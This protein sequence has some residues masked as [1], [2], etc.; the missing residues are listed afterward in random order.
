MMRRIKLFVY[1]ASRA[2]GL[3]WLARR[4]RLQRGLRILCYHGI[5]V[6]DGYEWKPMLFMRAETFE[7]RLATIRKLGL[8]VLDLEEAVKRMYEGSLPPNTVVITIDDGF[9]STFDAAV[10]ALL[11]FRMPATIYVTTYY[12]LKDQPIFELVLRYIHWKIGQS[13]DVDLAALG[14]KEGSE[15]VRFDQRV[16][17]RII[18]FGKA[19]PAEADRERV[20]RELAAQL[21]FDYE[22]IVHSGLLTL[23]SP[24]QIVEA[25]R[26]GIDIQLHTRR[27]RFP[28]IE[29]LAKAEIK[30]NRRDMEPIIGTELAHFCY[31]SGKW[32]AAQWPWLEELGVK[33]ATTCE[34]GLNYR[35]TPRYALFR[36]LDSDALSLVEFEAE[37]SG[38]SEIIRHLRTW[39]RPSRVAPGNCSP[40]AP[41]DP[42]VRHS[43][44]RPLD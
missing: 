8:T 4:S 40:G 42:D 17:E 5:S 36:Y 37:L 9:A 3:F 16:L 31:P 18:E 29:D 22:S 33:T 6:A 27:H 14:L 15:R 23:G 26:A 11:R 35:D 12:A 30:D 32:D 24:A 43:R 21:D 13:A 34:A 38:F 20:S 39:I 28:V 19:L 44:I 2:L 41:T 10:P 1:T 25:V 7:S